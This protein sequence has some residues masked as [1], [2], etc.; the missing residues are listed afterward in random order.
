[1]SDK[2]DLL[3]IANHI[4]NI[5][6]VNSYIFDDTGMSFTPEILYCKDC[7]FCDFNKKHLAGSHQAK[8]W[9]GRYIHYCDRGLIFIVTQTRQENT[10]FITGPIAMAENDFEDKDVPV[11]GTKGVGS[12]S[13]LLYQLLMMCSDD[14]MANHAKLKQHEILNTIYDNPTDLFNTKLHLEFEMELDSLIMLGD[15]EQVNEIINKIMGHIFFTGSYSFERVR[16]RTLEFIV[17]LS[18][19]VIK[20]GADAEEILKLT[21]NYTSEIQAIGTINNLNNWLPSVTRKYISYI[22]DYKLIKHKHIIYKVTNYIENNYKEKL[23]LSEVSAHVKLSNSYLSKIINDEIGCS[24]TVF[25]NQ[26]RIEKSKE[27]LRDTDLSL[28][29]ISNIVGFEDQSYFSKVFKKI[30]GFPPGK[31]KEQRLYN[32]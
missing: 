27:L 19:A 22:L 31:F 9:D 21:S 32:I 5:T 24:F 1:M 20:S 2:K 3:H 6:N 16:A 23:T 10:F 12:I 11:V 26:L 25:V 8:K 29:D 14:C 30:T 17:V 28:V 18:R 7:S 13:E 4:Y 15:K